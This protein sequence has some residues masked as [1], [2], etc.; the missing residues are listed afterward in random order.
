VSICSVR[1]KECLA[2]L[3]SMLGIFLLFTVFGY[4]LEAVNKMTGISKETLALRT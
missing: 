2:I 4:I 1:R 3:D